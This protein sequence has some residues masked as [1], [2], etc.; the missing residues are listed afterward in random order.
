MS[1][2]HE[3]PEQLEKAL[4]LLRESQLKV[5]DAR[6][7][8]IQILA[9]EHGPFTTEEVYQRLKKI[10]RKE[11]CDLVTVYRCLASFEKIGLVSRCDFRD[12][13]A[14]FELNLSKDHHHHHI[15]CKVCKK[16]ELLN[17][18]LIDALER[19]VREKGYSEVSHALEFFG[20]CGTCQKTSS[21]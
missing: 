17:I 4:K 1:H 21:S 13:N 15:I 7:A 3:H 2:S 20:V 14:R 8:I 10:L 11:N 6:K 18:C 16:V 5:T 12:G 19:L 9:N